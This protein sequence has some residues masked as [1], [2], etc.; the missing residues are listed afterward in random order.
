MKEDRKMDA[1]EKKVLDTMKKEGA[2]MK[3]GDI[4]QKAELD[5]NE[6]AKVI[7][8][9]KKDGKIS[10]PKRCFYAPV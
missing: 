9:L 1:A 4:A 6:V 5:K 3:S 7:E 2:P 8:R 10:S